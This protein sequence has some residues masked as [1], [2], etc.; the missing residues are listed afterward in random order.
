MQKG[1]ETKVAKKQRGETRKNEE[2]NE[3]KK[4]KNEKNEGREKEAACRLEAGWRHQ[5]C[6]ILT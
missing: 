2:N 3:K 6:A 4:A 1:G 5:T